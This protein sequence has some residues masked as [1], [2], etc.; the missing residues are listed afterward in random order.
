MPVGN[1]ETERYIQALALWQRGWG[2]RLGFGSIESY[3]ETIPKIPSI[4]LRPDKRFRF[5]V[6]VDGRLDVGLACGLSYVNARPEDLA[7]IMSF[8]ATRTKSGVRWMRCQ[9][10]RRYRAWTVEESRT[11][12]DQDE[13]GLDLSE[14][15]ALYAQYPRVLRGHNILLPNT[16][17]I[18]PSNSPGCVGRHEGGFH[19]GFNVGDTNRPAFGSASRL[20]H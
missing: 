7:L 11:K 18:R 3:L 12:F 8:D 4:L 16:V 1:A 2:E 5:L 13:F 10:G 14:A 17:S 15:L 6:L 9:T 19:F 20:D